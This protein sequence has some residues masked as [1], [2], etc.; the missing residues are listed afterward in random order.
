MEKTIKKGIG[1]FQQLANQKKLSSNKKVDQKLMVQ[2]A[3]PLQQVENLYFA[4]FSEFSERKKES[5]QTKG[6][7]CL[8]AEKKCN[9]ETLLKNI[10]EIE[11]V[12]G[13]QS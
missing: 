4:N 2:T 13:S 1:L 12:N 10:K 9:F 7:S 11:S 3:S 8:N 6:G 5:L